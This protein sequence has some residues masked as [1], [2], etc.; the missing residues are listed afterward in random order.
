MAEKTCNTCNKT[1][2]ATT[3]F[4]YVAKSNKDGL[5]CKCKECQ[6]Q[7]GRNRHAKKQA[8]KPPEKKR[9]Y[10]DINSL[11]KTC[12][13]CKIEKNKEEG[14]WKSKASR[15][16]YGSRCKKCSRATTKRWSETE[17]GKAKIRAR[18]R[19][20]RADNPELIKENKK[21]FRENNPESVKASIDKCWE[22]NGDQYKATHWR[23]WLGKKYGLTEDRYYEILEEQGY[24]CAICGALEKDSRKERF[25]VD[26]CHDTGVVRG[27]LCFACNVILGN[28]HDSVPLLQSAI[29]YLNRFPKEIA[30]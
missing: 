16:G 1:F 19:V 4:F 8:D 5:N 30:A 12:P 15:D 29:E 6:K 11:T 27:M 2:P 24:R 23:Y 26:H 10:L 13:A 25:C 20:W 3:E 17:I 28:A 9:K 14:F 22:K 7:Y 18:G 21:R